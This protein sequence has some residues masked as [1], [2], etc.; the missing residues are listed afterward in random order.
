MIVLYI[1]L[2]LIAVFLAV[3]LIRAAA[4]RPKEEPEKTYPEEEFDREKPVRS[5]AEMLQCRTVSHLRT[6]E[7]DDK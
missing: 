5:L 7:E 6:E 2:G 3:I 1:I 4:F